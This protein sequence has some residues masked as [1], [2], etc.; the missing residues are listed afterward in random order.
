MSARFRIRTAQGQELSFGSEEMFADFVRSGDLSPDDLVYDASTGEWC[1]AFTHSLVLEWEAERAEAEGDGRPSGSATE[2]GRSA[3]GPASGGAPAKAGSSGDSGASGSPPSEAAP[4]AGKPEGLLDFEL[5]P[6][7]SPEEAAAAF[8]EEMEAERASEI[9]RF[10]SIRGLEI[11]EGGTGLLK[12]ITDEP[13]GPARRGGAERTGWNDGRSRADEEPARARA[14]GDD[15][16]RPPDPSPVR[17][18]SAPSRHSSRGVSRAFLAWAL[19]LG[20]IGAGVL[21]ASDIAAVALGIAEPEAPEETEGPPLLPDTEEALR[22]RASV[23]FL[24]RVRQNLGTLPSVP[25]IWLDG[26][27]LA[28]APA[29]PEVR[30]V[31]A[32]YLGSVGAVRAREN[33]H[34]RTAYLSALDDARVTGATRTLRLASA[35]SAFEGSSAAR[36]AHYD[37]VTELASAALDLHDFLVAHAEGIAYEPAVGLRVSADPVLQAAAA[38]PTVQAELEAALDRVLDA[39]SARGSGPVDARAVPG[40]TFQGLRDIVSP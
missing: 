24:A 26:R 9:D 4:P 25:P 21:L 39:L 23:R 5:S 22:E 1:S 19:L 40:W 14:S 31:W 32:R 36:D 15:R 8:V 2:P 35:G 3:A 33:E 27:Y 37:R 10:Q 38:D 29:Y 11:D 20:L 18:A 7:R 28:D 6:E 34:Y 30:E 16:V 13:A 17:S 12:G